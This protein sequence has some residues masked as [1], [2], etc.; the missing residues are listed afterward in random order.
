MDAVLAPQVLEALRDVD[1]LARLVVGLVQV[2][3]AGGGASSR[4]RGP[5]PFEAGAE[6]RVAPHH[7][8]R[9]R[10]GDPVADEVRLPEHA[11]GVPNGGPRLDR[12]ESDDLGDVVGAVPLGGVTDHLAPPAFVE[13]HVDV[14]HLLAAGIEEALEQQVVADRVEVDDPQAVGDEASGRRAPA[15]PDPDAVGAGVADQVPHDEEIRRETH[16]ADHPELELHPLD[17]G[18]GERGAVP[19]VRPLNREVPE[20]GRS[21]FLV[22]RRRVT[23]RGGGTGAAPAC[24]ARSRPRPARRCRSVLSQASACSA[25]SRRISTAVFR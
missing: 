9:H 21:P 23:R 5:R 2:P 10:L 7:E 8:R 19:F 17:D 14:G 22:A 3:E 6:R 13:V 15:R 1:D 20:I 18:S 4:P 24:R 16:R 25:N 12:R 11:G